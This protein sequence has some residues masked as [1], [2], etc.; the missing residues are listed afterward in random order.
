[1]IK[2]KN[3]NKF[4][5]FGSFRIG[6]ILKAREKSSFLTIDCCWFRTCHKTVCLGAI[7]NRFRSPKSY[8]V[9]CK[10]AR[11]IK[12]ELT[13]DEIWLHIYSKRPVYVQ[14]YYLLKKT[15]QVQFKFFRSDQCTIVKVFVNTKLTAF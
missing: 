13:S 7:R 10:I 5:I 15:N 11:E 1:M 3:A 8:F 9:R 12:L 2:L 4:I 6:R 14:T